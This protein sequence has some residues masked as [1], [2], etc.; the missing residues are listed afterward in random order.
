[1][2]LE[3]CHHDTFHNTAKDENLKKHSYQRIQE[4]TS[5]CVY[6]VT[7]SHLHRYNSIMK[8]HGLSPQVKC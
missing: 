8:T 2:S 3:E 4:Q 5:K 1:M 6:L 7:I